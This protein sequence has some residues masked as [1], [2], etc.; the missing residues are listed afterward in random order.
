M[1]GLCGAQF[2]QKRGGPM[3]SV[4]YSVMMRGDST[5]ARDMAFAQY[6]ASWGVMMSYGWGGSCG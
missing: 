3:E 2:D 5:Y 1:N 4:K 6:S